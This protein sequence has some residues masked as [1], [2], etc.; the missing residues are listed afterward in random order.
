MFNSSCNNKMFSQYIFENRDAAEFKTASSKTEY[1]A[2]FVTGHIIYFLIMRWRE[3]EVSTFIS[4]NNC[5]I[6][7]RN[8][9]FN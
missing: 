8:G 9:K 3:A 6:K 2:D 4:S 5:I 7:H 1:N